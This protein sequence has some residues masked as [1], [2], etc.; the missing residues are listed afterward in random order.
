MKITEEYLDELIAL[1]E[2]NLA[3]CKEN[4]WEDLALHVEGALR[5][6]YTVKMHKVMS[7]RT[8]FLT[9]KKVSIKK[10]ILT[11]LKDKLEG[12]ED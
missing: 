6:L 8:V 7:G 10:R 11:W 5:A 3:C 9:K 12:V 1:E 4:G 2:N